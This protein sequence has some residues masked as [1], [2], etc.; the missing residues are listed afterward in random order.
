MAISVSLNSFVFLGNV[1]KT[2]G[3]VQCRL[4]E[5]NMESLYS[6][7]QVIFIGKCL[8]CDLKFIVHNI[9]LIWLVMVGTVGHLTCPLFHLVLYEFLYHR[10]C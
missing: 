4:F 5:G 10:Y 3:Y 7:E 8:T 6:D 9:L 1:L 2:N